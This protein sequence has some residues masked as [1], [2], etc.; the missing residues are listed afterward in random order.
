[1]HTFIHNIVDWWHVVLVME[2]Y[3]LA[4]KMCILNQRMQS[5]IVVTEA[6][7]G[8]KAK[9]NVKVYQSSVSQKEECANLIHSHNSRLHS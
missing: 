1:M 2:L 6:A 9:I 5:C 3:L 4:E 8:A 7:A